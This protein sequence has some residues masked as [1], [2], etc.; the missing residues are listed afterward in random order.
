MVL[1][2][3]HSLVLNPAEYVQNS[4]D[5][6]SKIF[7]LSKLKYCKITYRIKIDDD[8]LP[9]YFSKYDYSPVE[10][11]SINARFPHGSLNNLLYCFPK[12]RRLSI[13]YLVHSRSQDSESCP[14]RLLKGLKYV[15]LKSYLIKF[16]TFEKTVQ[17]FFR[18][19]EVL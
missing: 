13:D 3:L 10:H 1:P 18:H 7:R 15:S 19:V 9:D 2:N 17:N 4:T 6:F 16:N 8:P 5:V 11:L 14:I 12:L